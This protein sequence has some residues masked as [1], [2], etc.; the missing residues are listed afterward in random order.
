[1]PAV[2]PNESRNDYVARCVPICMKE[3]LDQKAAVGKC[4]GIFM[5]HRKTARKRGSKG[6]G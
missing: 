3:G 6:K 4:E 2:K 5:S 1:M